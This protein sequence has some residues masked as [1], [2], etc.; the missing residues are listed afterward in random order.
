[1]SKRSDQQSK[2]TEQVRHQKHNEVHL[3][4]TIMMTPTKNKARNRSTNLSRFSTGEYPGTEMKRREESSIRLILQ[5]FKQKKKC[6]KGLMPMLPKWKKY[7]TKD[8]RGMLIIEW[9]SN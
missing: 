8:G 9:N 6:K 2:E 3:P 1:M 5:V 4:P 7:E